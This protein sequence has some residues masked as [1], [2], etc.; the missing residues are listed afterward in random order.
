MSKAIAVLVLFLALAA[1]GRQTNSQNSEN[2][3]NSDQSAK[4]DV[5]QRWGKPFAPA[6]LPNGLL[7]R[8]G[9]SPNKVQD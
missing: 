6:G 4:S 2:A 9:S 1:W 5:Q 7:N 3:Q 8:P